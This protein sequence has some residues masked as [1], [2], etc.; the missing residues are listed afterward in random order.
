MTARILTMSA[1]AAILL[2]ATPAHAADPVD[3][4]G[5]WDQPAVGS[6]PTPPMGWNSW[7]AF[8]LDLTEAGLMAQARALVDQGYAALGYRTVNI[9]DGWWLKR[10]AG[11]GRMVV[12]TNVFPG[13]ALAGGDTS[14]RGWT[15]RLHAMGLRAG[16][17][18]DIGRNACSQ[19]WSDNPATLPEGTREEREVGLYGHVEQDIALYFGAWNF[20]T[21]KVDGCG[22][23]HYGTTRAH[24]ANGRFRALAPLINDTDPGLDDIPA[25]VALY[26]HLRDAL[27]RQRPRGDFVLSLCNWGT[28]NV[29]DWG[30]HVGTMWRTSGDIDPTWG[31][32]LHNF[33]SVVTREFYAGPGHWNDPDMLEVGN[34]DFD[35]AHLT[36]ARAHLALWAIV[37]APLIIG[38]DLAAAPPAI[39]TVLTN[40]EVIAVDQDPAGHQGITAYADDERQIIVR[41]LATRG[42]K[43]VLLFNRQPVPTTVTLTAQQLKMAAEAPIALR[44][45]DQHRDLGTMTGSRRFDLAPHQALLLRA[46]GTPRL[47]RGWYLSEVPALVHVGADGIVA[48]E[49][50]PTI[51][52]MIDPHTGDTTGSGLR[53]TYAG[54]GAPRADATPYGGALTMS[55]TVWR[56][57]LGVIANSRLQVAARGGFAR[58]AARVGVDDSS[59]G[60]AAGVQFE[61]WG[62]GRR[63]A[64]S[65]VQHFGVA[66]VDLAAD[67]RGVQVIE[68]VARQVGGDSA[69]VIATW[70]E[71]RV[72]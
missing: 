35:G 7:N 22:I 42:T 63:L 48:P 10:R 58:F 6:A 26:S 51:H 71:A 57:G 36:E 72:E 16:I 23:A 4:S 54:W 12:R 27:Q 44:D 1:L 19:A 25:T 15:D 43:A 70:A 60:R 38:T 14:L 11:D 62:D 8:H 59:R 69:P 49:P 5:T 39:R 68:L 65:P 33:D 55:G 28:A 45:L 52:R 61:V 41:T 53:P 3:P 20:D 47:E 30:R 2:G 29:R 32:M 67:V 46:S 13:A 34:G 24:V 9:D 18:S 31:R 40:P 37:A 64:S 56:D 50:D 17:Y 66:P 21:I